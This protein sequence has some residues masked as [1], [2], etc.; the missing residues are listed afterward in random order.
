[1]LYSLAKEARV[2]VRMATLDDLPMLMA[3]GQQFVDESRWGVKFDPA[4]AE[5]TIRAYIT[6][7]IAAVLLAEHEGKCLGG[8]MLV[9]E[10]DCQDKPFGMWGKFYML[11][12][13]RG[14][15]ASRMLARAC[16]DWFD[17]KG[18]VASFTGATANIGNDRLF[19][20]LMKK[21]GYV[22]AP[23]MPTLIRMGA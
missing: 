17:A 6:L 9:L 18:C 21:V 1:M 8:A 14:T 5:H 7:P 19:A 15:R 11:P 16:V 3:M 4:R 10:W 20:N 23:N 12:E 22:E 2:F 13:A